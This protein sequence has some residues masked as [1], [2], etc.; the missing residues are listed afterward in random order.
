MRLV[1][2]KLPDNP[3]K[4]VN[5]LLLCATGEAHLLFVRWI[6]EE[7]QDSIVIAHDDDMDGVYEDMVNNWLN[8]DT[9]DM[10][11][12]AKNLAVIASK[13]K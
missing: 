1:K 2:Y 13:L 7:R 11:E 5:A 8:V 9:K 6:D 4:T 3:H 10:A 12:I